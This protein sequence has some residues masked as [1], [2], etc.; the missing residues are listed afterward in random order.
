M[1]CGNGFENRSKKPMYNAQDGQL[2]LHIEE[3]HSAKI[4]FQETF[5]NQNDESFVVVCISQPI[6]SNIV[7]QITNKSKLRKNK[8]SR[9][10]CNYMF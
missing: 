6:E 10:Y 2:D 7:F 4:L 5:F 9:C 1:Q 3:F 8:F